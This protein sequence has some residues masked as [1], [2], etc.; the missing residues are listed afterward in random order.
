MPL[1]K[2]ISITHL[3]IWSLLGISFLLVGLFDPDDKSIVG[4]VISPVFIS[5][6]VL[7]WKSYRFHS[8]NIAR[9]LLFLFVPTSMMVLFFLFVMYLLFLADSPSI[10]ING[11]VVTILFPLISVVYFKLVWQNYRSSVKSD[12]K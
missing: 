7:S 2:L 12:G 8:E 11:V 6:A 3:I 5:L 1:L 4:L 10:K 9:S